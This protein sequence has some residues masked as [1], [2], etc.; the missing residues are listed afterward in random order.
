MILP[1]SLSVS[2]A[3]EFEPDPDWKISACLWTTGLTGEMGIGPIT[4][5]EARTLPS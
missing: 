2:W 1:G 4:A 3:S 5:D